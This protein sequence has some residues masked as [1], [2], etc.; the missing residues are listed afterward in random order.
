MQ[1]KR[2][3]GLLLIGSCVILA[4]FTICLCVGRTQ[5]LADSAYTEMIGANDVVGGS[6]VVM[7]ENMPEDSVLFTP[8]ISDAVGAND[9]VGGSGAVMEENMSEDSMLFIPN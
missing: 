4:V 9:A 2:N 3:W 7:E 5:S 8:N 1:K 6:G